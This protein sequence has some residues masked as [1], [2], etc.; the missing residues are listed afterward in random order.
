MGDSANAPDANK[1]GLEITVSDPVKQGEGLSSFISYKVHVRC[2][3]PPAGRRLLT[4]PPAHAENR[5]R[6]LES[7]PAPCCAWLLPLGRPRAR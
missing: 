3:A 6:R 7:K 1:A 2:A 4:R 5:P